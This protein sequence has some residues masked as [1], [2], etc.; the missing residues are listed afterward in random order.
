MKRRR[1]EI[2]DDPAKYHIWRP[3]L[4]QYRPTF[5]LQCENAITWSNAFVR[6]QLQNVMF[7]RV[8]DRKAKAAGIVRKLAQYNKGHD[9]HI[10]IDE[11]KSI[12]LKIEQ[13]EDNPDFQDL[14]LTVHHCFMHTF[15]STGAY[16]A[17]ENHQGVAMAVF[18]KIV[19]TFFT[20]LLLYCR[21]P[22]VHRRHAQD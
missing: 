15:M 13:L 19:V 6:E 12:G 10:H 21:V 3:V 16:K 2:K 18:V 22:R 4:E 11:C 17:I 5:L 20:Q 1:T 9:R 8:R 7:A 14:V